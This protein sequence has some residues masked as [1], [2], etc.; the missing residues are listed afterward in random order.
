MTH[1]LLHVACHLGPQTKKDDTNKPENSIQA[2]MHTKKDDTNYDACVIV[3]IIFF[4]M[5]HNLYHLSWFVAPD[6]TQHAAN[7]AS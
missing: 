7:Y 4:G 6:G 2:M 1:S 3:C 5:R